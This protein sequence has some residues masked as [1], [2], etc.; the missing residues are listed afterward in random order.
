[1]KQN[2]CKKTGI[3]GGTFNPIHCGHLHLAE[4]ALQT[5]GLDE[6]LFVPSGI[7]YMKDQ[8]EI[9]PARER[10]EMVRLAIQEYPAFMVSS[11]ETDKQSNSYSHET[12]RALQEAQPDTEYFF[13]TGADTIFSMEDWKDPVS[14]FRS[15]TILAACRPGVSQ[16]G[17]KKQIS[18]LHTQYQADIRLISADY[19]DI[20][21][22]EIRKA[23]KSGKSIRGL[24]PQIVEGYILKNHLYH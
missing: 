12:I 7:S 6:I 19:V 10:L 14:I 13:L 18:Y 16:D 8:K 20:S 11:I 23:I 9:L 24:V 22:S 4:K 2:H 5:A 17:L 21:S 3:F 1:M 15:V